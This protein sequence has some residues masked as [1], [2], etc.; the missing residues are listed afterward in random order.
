ME[1]VAAGPSQWGVN[2]LPPFSP[3][4]VSSVGVLKTVGPT[5][6][7]KAARAQALTLTALPSGTLDFYWVGEFVTPALQA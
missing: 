3:S 2:I 4:P 5:M 7:Q 1:N 6:L